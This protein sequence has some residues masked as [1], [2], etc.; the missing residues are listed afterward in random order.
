MTRRR[1]AARPIGRLAISL[2]HCSDIHLLFPCF[3]TNHASPRIARN[4]KRNRE[5]SFLLNDRAPVLP[6]APSSS[7]QEPNRLRMS[8]H[9][10][11]FGVLLWCRTQ[12]EY[13]VS[14]DQPHALPC[15]PCSAIWAL[16]IFV[17][18]IFEPWLSR[19]FANI[20]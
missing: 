14:V 8:P 3:L 12:D 17:V 9:Q 2:H 16:T 4:H 5:T 18:F 20:G 10:G 13:G 11:L 6:D 15:R 7:E 19:V 1:L